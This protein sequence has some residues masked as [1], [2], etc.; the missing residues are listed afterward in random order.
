MVFFSTAGRHI[1]GF[2][3]SCLD[4][5]LTEIPRNVCIPACTVPLNTPCPE[6]LIFPPR[7]RPGLTSSD[8]QPSFLFPAP[9][10]PLTCIPHALPQLA[11][12]FVQTHLITLLTRCSGLGELKLCRNPLCPHTVHST[13]AVSKLE[14]CLSVIPPSPSF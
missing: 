10:A 14:G 3:I 9:V 2:D 5:N 1:L 8:H 12:T 11:A 13:N 4:L 6:E 7:Y